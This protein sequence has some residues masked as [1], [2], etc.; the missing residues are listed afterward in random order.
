[1]GKNSKTNKFQQFAKKN[2]SDLR[3]A[4]GKPA[5]LQIRTTFPEGGIDDQETFF[6]VRIFLNPEIYG[7]RTAHTLFLIR[8]KSSA[9]GL[10]FYRY[11]IPW[12][13][14]TDCT[15]AGSFDC[16]Q[17]AGPGCCEY[18]NLTTSISNYRK[19]L[20]SFRL[21]SVELEPEQSLPEAVRSVRI[22]LTKLGI[23]PVNNVIPFFTY[24][25][26]RQ[27]LDE[28]CLDEAG[29]EAV[30]TAGLR[31]AVANHLDTIR[32]DDFESSKLSLY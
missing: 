17:I 12:E 13:I 1:M 27:Q 16:R 11:W 28:I 20:F 32:V 31:T 14:P 19:V 9:N 10:K 26:H 25:K 29:Q 8:V 23:F 2:V 6:G 7:E 4:F 18:W 22:R 30:S 24:E 5:K 21:T 3:I 15:K